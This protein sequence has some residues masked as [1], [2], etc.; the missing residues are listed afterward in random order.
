MKS[1]IGMEWHS[2][3]ERLCIKPSAPT[4]QGRAGR[5][6]VQQKE[7]AKERVKQQGRIT[8]SDCGHS[9]PGYLSLRNNPKILQNGMTVPILF[10]GKFSHL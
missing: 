3:T 2:Q 1:Y 4:P 5:L 10:F 9:S 7:E 8:R 6:L